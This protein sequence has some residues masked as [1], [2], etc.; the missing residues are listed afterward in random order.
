MSV[1]QRLSRNSKLHKSLSIMGQRVKMLQALGI[2]SCPFCGNSRPENTQLEQDTDCACVD[3]LHHVHSG[4][5]TTKPPTKQFIHGTAAAAAEARPRMCSGKLCTRASTP[6][7][8]PWGRSR[9]AYASDVAP[10]V[11]PG[12][13]HM[14]DKQAHRKLP[15]YLRHHTV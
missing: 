11:V 2:H 1:T 15:G 5:H 8:L 4:A 7:E 6:Q 13:A 9:L 14:Q 3:G 10:Y 12:P